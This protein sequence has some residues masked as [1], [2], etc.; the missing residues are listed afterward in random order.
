MAITKGW[1]YFVL[2]QKEFFSAKQ[3]KWAQPG[4]WLGDNQG[5]RR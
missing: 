3:P 1:Q 2:H 4:G 5:S